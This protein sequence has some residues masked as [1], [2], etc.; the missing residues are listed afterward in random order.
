[1][2]LQGEKPQ[3]PDRPGLVLTP[4]R[5]KK[6]HRTTS[7]LVI[8]SLIGGFLALLL[9]GVIVLWLLPAKVN[10]A[11]RIPQPVQQTTLPQ[12]ASGTSATVQAQPGRQEAEQLLSEWLGRQAVAEAENVSTWGGQE[13]A[14]ILQSVARADQLFKDARFDGAQQTYRKAIDDF[15]ALLAQ[16]GDLFKEAL[17]RGQQALEQ[18][19]QAAA[20][21]AFELAL[22]IDPDHEEAQRGAKRAAG[23][24]QVLTLYNRALKLEEEKK[25]EQARQLLQEAVE[26]DPE[27]IPAV[28]ALTRVQKRMQDIR[29]QDAMSRALTALDRD[30]LAAAD[31]ALSEARRNRPGDPAA[32]AAG[33]LLEEKKKSATLKELRT[34]ADSHVDAEQWAEAMRVYTEALKIDPQAGFAVSGQGEAQRR[35]QLDQ[36][37]RTVLAKPER[38]QDKGPLSDAQKLLERA[39]TVAEPGPVLREQVSRLDKLIT[40]AATPVEVT[41]RS[42]NATVVEIYHVGRFSPFLEKQLTLRPGKYTIVGKRPGYKDVRMTIQIDAGRDMPLFVFIRSEEPI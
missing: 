18:Q 28:D 3:K 7:P 42:D 33:L 13:Y 21:Q 30:D 23:L 29:F 31:Q 17:H 35:Q 36:A 39:E 15:E 25:L 41:L 9:L 20:V 2:T 5:E 12:E 11:P 37:I 40:S 8:V 24:E 4:P 14:D 6:P 27:F 26:Q 32:K 1:M 22:A 19:D 10:R 38:L 34:R 16:K